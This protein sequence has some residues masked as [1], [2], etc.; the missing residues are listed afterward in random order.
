MGPLLVTGAACFGAALGIG[1]IT[2]AASRALAETSEPKALRGLQMLLLATE[3]AIG[4]LGVVIGILGIVIAGVGDT[5]SAIVAAVPAL[6]GMAAG[7][8]L[9]LRTDRGSIRA[10]PIAFRFMGGLGLLGVVAGIEAVTIGNGHTIRGSDGLFAI[11]AVVFLSAALFGGVSGARGLA[12]LRVPGTLE[13][14][15]ARAISRALL[16]QSS[17]IVAAVVAVIII[18]SGAPKAG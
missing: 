16:V 6:G 8:I 7:M 11:V 13:R 12:G 18:V 5:S 10:Q 14:V 3:E 9:A 4:V 2:A 17:A 1:L 15:R